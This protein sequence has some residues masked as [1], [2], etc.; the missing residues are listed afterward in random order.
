MSSYNID[1][2]YTTITSTSG[3]ILN[4]DSTGSL[5]IAS[6]ATTAG[7]FTVNGSA[8]MNQLNQ[9]GTVTIGTYQTGSTS[10]GYGYSGTYPVSQPISISTGGYIWADPVP[11]DEIKSKPEVTEEHAH[12]IQCRLRVETTK[13]ISE[14]FCHHCQ[15]VLFSKV[16]SRLPK[17]IINKKCLSRIV[18]GV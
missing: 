6:S 11:A 4:V 17:G 16:I 3:N 2:T 15:E 1:P 13:V 5:Q 9:T 7:P 18:K 8:S 14:Y 12:S 10:G